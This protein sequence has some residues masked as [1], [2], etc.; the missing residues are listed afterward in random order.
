MYPCSHKESFSL[1]S[2]EPKSTFLWSLW[3]GWTSVSSHIYYLVE[4]QKKLFLKHFSVSLACCKIPPHVITWLFFTLQITALISGRI[5]Y[6]TKAD[7]NS[8]ISIYGVH[9]PWEI[10]STI[11]QISIYGSELLFSGLQSV[12]PGNLLGVGSKRFA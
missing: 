11:F 8:Y 5:I 1:S 2:E 7:F 4:N 9:G 6:S 10:P 12:E 3:F